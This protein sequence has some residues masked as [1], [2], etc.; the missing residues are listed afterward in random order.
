MPV[1]DMSAVLCV[2]SVE[3]CIPRKIASCTL[4]VQVVDVWP[5]R[6][7]W[8]GGQVGRRLPLAIVVVMGNN[9]DRWPSVAGHQ[10]RALGQR[11]A[12]RAR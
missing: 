10:L 1:R 8:E 4:T 9:D 3:A 12:A 11:I 2:S 5:G 6:V 7:K